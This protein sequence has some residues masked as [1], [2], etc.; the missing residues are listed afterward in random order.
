MRIPF[1]SEFWSFT[2]N[3]CKEVAAIIKITD[4]T[5]SDKIIFFY[6][7]N[8]N[9]SK[10]SP[11][12][13]HVTMWIKRQCQNEIIKVHSGLLDVTDDAWYLKQI[14]RGN[15]HFLEL[16]IKDFNRGWQIVRN[17]NV[18]SFFIKYFDKQ[19]RKIISDTFCN[20]I[21]YSNVEE[22]FYH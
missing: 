11:K 4:Q 20:L 21:V 6:N 15:F 16:I 2:L 8:R 17:M 10:G 22:E 19:T 18:S 14:E 12:P 7:L 1:L 13:S 3:W 9:K 5:M